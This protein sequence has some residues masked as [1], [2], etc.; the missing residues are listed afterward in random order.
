MQR[1]ERRDRFVHGHDDKEFCTARRIVMDLSEG[2]LL[3]K[4]LDEPRLNKE[5]RLE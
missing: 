5:Q 4:G 1:F 2:K 3:W